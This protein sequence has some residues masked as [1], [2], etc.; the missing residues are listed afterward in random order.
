MMRLSLLTRVSVCGK[1]GNLLIMIPYFRLIVKFIFCNKQNCQ[2]HY[3]VLHLVPLCQVAGFAPQG[4]VVPFRQSALRIRNDM[5]CI[6]LT[7]ASRAREN[8]IAVGAD[9]AA[10]VFVEVSHKVGFFPRCWK[11]ASPWIAHGEAWGQ[12]VHEYASTI[13][14][15]RSFAISH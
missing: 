6:K 13:L 10:A 5:V 14:D 15:K 7:K 11:L 3:P 2:I 4:K 8:L 9:V 1:F 12:C